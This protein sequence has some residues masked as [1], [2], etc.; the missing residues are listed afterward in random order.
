VFEAGGGGCIPPS[1]LDPPLK[2]EESRGTIYIGGMGREGEDE[3]RDPRK[4]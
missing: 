1:P 4:Q 2:R 3:E